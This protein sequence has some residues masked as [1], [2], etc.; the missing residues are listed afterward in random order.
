MNRAM[1]RRIKYDMSKEPVDSLSVTFNC[2]Q[3]L[4][5]SKGWDLET[6]FEALRNYYMSLPESKRLLGVYDS[7]GHRTDA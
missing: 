5:L 6:T 7:D 4:A 1:R 3:L 2:L